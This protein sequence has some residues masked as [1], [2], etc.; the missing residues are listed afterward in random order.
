M[1][2]F[3]GCTSC[4]RSL[5]KVYCG[6][7]PAQDEDSTRLSGWSSAISSERDTFGGGFNPAYPRGCGCRFVFPE[8]RASGVE[9]MNLTCR[10]RFWLRFGRV[11]L[12]TTL[13]PTW[14]LWLLAL[15]SLWATWA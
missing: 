4:L 6:A 10:M 2:C 12:S 15:P 3:I 7:G 5:R 11:L 13:A 9:S 14:E 8:K 1:S